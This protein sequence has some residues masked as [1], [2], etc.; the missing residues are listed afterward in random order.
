MMSPSP[1][2]LPNPARTAERL[3]DRAGV[4]VPPIDLSKVVSSWPNLTVVEE[5]LERAGYLLSIGELGAEILVNVSDKEERKRFT[6]AHEIGHWVLGLALKKKTGHFSQP[7]NAHYAE[8]ERWCDGFATNL[9]MPESMIRTN[10]PLGE[11]TVD[12][13]SLTHGASIFKVSEHAFFLRIWEV[14]RLQVALVSIATGQSGVLVH[15]EKSFGDPR[16]QVELENMLKRADTASKLQSAPRFS[17]SW[18]SHDGRVKC[19][20]RRINI[21]HVLLALKWPDKAT[22]VE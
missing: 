16:V 15:V 21:D 10:I 2:K 12:L 5:E 3:L 17:F 19:F 14:L 22:N 11:D 20:G 4:L 13:E 6:I 8:I 1:T 18:A 9:L 7:K